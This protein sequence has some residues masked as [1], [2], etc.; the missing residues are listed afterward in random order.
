MATESLGIAGE[1]RVCSVKADAVPAGEDVG[2]IVL[3]L[4]GDQLEIRLS[5]AG[6]SHCE[7]H[8]LWRSCQHPRNFARDWAPERRLRPIKKIFSYST[9]GSDLI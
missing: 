1:A 8:S 6:K 5:V 7:G 4:D 2:G 3:F 9:G